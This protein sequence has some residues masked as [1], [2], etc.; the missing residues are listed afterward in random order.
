M[1]PARG[2]PHLC[3]VTRPVRA[4]KRAHERLPIDLE[5]RGRGPKLVDNVHH[6]RHIPVAAAGHVKGREEDEAAGGLGSLERA[7]ELGV[8]EGV[9]GA[10]VEGEAVDAYGFGVVDFLGPLV[11]GLAVDDADLISWISHHMGPVENTWDK[12]N[13]E[14]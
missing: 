12:L 14:N 2:L 7:L 8:R 4:L 5:V 13:G 1:N 10:D 3:P 6:L 11:G 9:R